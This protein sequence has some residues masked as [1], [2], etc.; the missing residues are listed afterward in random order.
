MRFKT[1][2]L[3][4]EDEYTRIDVEDQYHGGPDGLQYTSGELDRIFRTREISHVRLL[5]C[6]VKGIGLAI[7]K[8]VEAQLKLLAG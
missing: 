8:R 2:P 7:K 5:Q 6:C 3:G 4:V 1:P